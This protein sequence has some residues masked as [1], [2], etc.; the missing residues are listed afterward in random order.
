MLSGCVTPEDLPQKLDS[1]EE[2]SDVVVY[3]VTYELTYDPVREESDQ[4][5][6]LILERDG[7]FFMSVNTCNGVDA[8]EGTFTIEGNELFI[9]PGK[10]YCN[11]DDIED[12]CDPR[13]FK[14]IIEN[15]NRL[16]IDLGL[17]CIAQD[18]IFETK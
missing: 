4:Y 5:S 3:N 17:F 18:S 8:I 14:F 12:E 6:Y 2:V 7:T 10:Y 16:I 13:G 1:E 11:V 9:N 15:P